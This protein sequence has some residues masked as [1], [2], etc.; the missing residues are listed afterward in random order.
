MMMSRKLMG[1]GMAACAVALALP[2]AAQDANWYLTGAVGRSKFSDAAGASDTKDT[3][4]NVGL[5]YNFNRTF[6]LEGGYTDF[7]KVRFPGFSGEAHSP[8]VTAL[9]TA[10]IADAWSIYG[11]LGMART[12]RKVSGALFGGSEHKTEAY[13]G[14]GTAYAF[15][16]KVSGTLEWQKLDDTNVSAIA[17]GIKVAF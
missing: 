9:L 3:S 13:Y 4:Y 12:E 7:G 2:A 11:R 1:L 10:P 5:G 14:L 8:Y 17:V 16:R 15:T 6:G